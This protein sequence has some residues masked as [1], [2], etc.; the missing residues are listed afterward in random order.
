MTRFRL[1]AL[2]LACL[3]GLLGCQA[4]GP[5]PVQPPKADA[6]TGLT[7]KGRLV[8][9]PGTYR[10]Q[11]YPDL[12]GDYRS[13]GAPGIR[14]Y[15]ADDVATYT[16]RLYSRLPAEADFGAT[17]VTTVNA[18]RPDALFYLANLKPELHYRLVI[19]A[20]DATNQL[21]NATESSK[22]DFDTVASGGVYETANDLVPVPVTL[23]DKP[24]SG[25]L[26]VTREIADGF[27]GVRIEL[28]EDSGQ[29]AASGSALASA[30]LVGTGIG[31][32]TFEN[33]AHDKAYFIRSRI[34][35]SSFNDLIEASLATTVVDVDD[36]ASVSQ[37]LATLTLPVYPPVDN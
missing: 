9:Q 2:S 15:Q 34:A 17:P 27:H 19:E 3:A 7:F 30:D 11:S 1:A 20:Y 25:S 21:I 12:H 6:P 33:L 32:I 16:A 24:F 13:D 23:L 22:V 8:V 29:G 31:Q 36:Y 14:G 37:T 5:A 10:L 28:F 4:R 18:A 35:S 26:D